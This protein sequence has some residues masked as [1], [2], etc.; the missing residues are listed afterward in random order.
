M[1]HVV[2]FSTGKMSTVH[3]TGMHGTSQVLTWSGMPLNHG[4]Q[5]TR[6]CTRG[7]FAV[8]C[9]CIGIQW[10]LPPVNLNLDSRMRELAGVICSMAASDVWEGLQPVTH[11][12]R[13]MQCM[14]FC[15]ALTGAFLLL[16]TGV[17]APTVAWRLS[18]H[19]W[20]VLLTAH[21]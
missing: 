14:A 9:T 16:R 21:L 5:V 18:T 8:Q 4:A 1:A 11:R 17:G 7:D 6:S 20:A 2:A 3:D 10:R 13:Q 19:H 12:S 15:S